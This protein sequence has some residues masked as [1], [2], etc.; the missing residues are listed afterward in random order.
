MSISHSIVPRVPS[1]GDYV[2][3][4]RV[5]LRRSYYNRVC[6]VSFSRP[7]THFS[8]RHHWWGEISIPSW[9]LL[10]SVSELL[11]V[12]GGICS[13]MPCGH[14]VVMSLSSTHTMCLSLVTASSFPQFVLCLVEFHLSPSL[15]LMV[16][17]LDLFRRSCW[18]SHVLARTRSC[19]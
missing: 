12:N 4:Q 2:I 11:Y 9:L 6:F 19:L 17:S 5:G 15:C 13:P 16:K 3:V 1:D 7:A 10:D 14:Y 18:V 8:I